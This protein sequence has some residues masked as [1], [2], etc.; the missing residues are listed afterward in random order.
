MMKR[1][2]NDALDLE[3][4]AA[5]DVRRN[6]RGIHGEDAV[7]LHHAHRRGR[8]ATSPIHRAGHEPLLLRGHQPGARVVE[9]T[10]SADD[11]RTCGRQRRFL[12][13]EREVGRVD[14]DRLVGQ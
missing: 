11:G 7:R 3:R 13:T 6:R 12:L 10:A 4:E 9:H 1:S 8:D 2:E 14:L 5:L